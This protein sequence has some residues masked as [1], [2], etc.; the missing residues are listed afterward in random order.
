M[1]R[2]TFAISGRQYIQ[3]RLHL[4]QMSLLN[5]LKVSKVCISFVSGA[6]RPPGAV[7][8]VPGERK[9]GEEGHTVPSGG[10][11]LGHTVLLHQQG[12]GYTVPGG[13]EGL[14][15]T[16]RRPLEPPAQQQPHR[17][18]APSG[19]V[20]PSSWLPLVSKS[21]PRACSRVGSF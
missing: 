11:G 10:E 3:S 18:D 14:G 12:L 17:R 19:L 9:G 5:F 15:R 1:S 16:V 2:R 13:E 7:Q 21:N 6:A 4:H 8:E 20:P